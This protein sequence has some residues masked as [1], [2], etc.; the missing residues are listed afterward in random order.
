MC[1]R[2]NLLGWGLLGRQ[3]QRMRCT[4]NGWRIIFKNQYPMNVIGHYHK[5]VQLDIF[6][7]VFYF[8]PQYIGN[9]SRG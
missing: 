2:G 1:W 8:G 9:R 3:V 4:C 6:C 7:V 5:F